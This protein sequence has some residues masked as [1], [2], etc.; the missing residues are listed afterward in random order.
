MENRF[1][2]A[3]SSD[4]HCYSF[5]LIINKKHMNP[6]FTFQV[7]SDGKT[8]KTEPMTLICCL[9]PVVTCQEL[10]IM[11]STGSGAFSLLCRRLRIAPAA[12][13]TFVRIIT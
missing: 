12:V 11:I 10:A 5:L 7:R 1:F 6:K 2:E 3:G 9:N 8:L 13:M 4:T